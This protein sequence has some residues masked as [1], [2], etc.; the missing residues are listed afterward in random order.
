MK[1]RALLLLLASSGCHGGKK[2][3][4][5]SRSLLGVAKNA[6]K[7]SDAQ[8]LQSVAELNHLG[9]LAREALAR[10]PSR[11]PATVVSELLFGPLG[12][13]REVSD[14]A[15]DFVLLPSVL[16]RRRGSCV[17]L[18]TLFLALAER[19]GWSASGVMMPGHFYVRLA[20][21]SEHR[22]VEL[23][24]AGEAMPDTWYAERFP[25]PDGA[26]AE[27][28]RPLSSQEVLGVL[29][30]NVGNDHR[31]ARRIDEARAA[32][33]RSVS[34]FPD[35]SEAHAS[36]GAML[37]LL[38]QLDQ[39]AQSYRAARAKNP[40]LPGLDENLALLAAERAEAA[41]RR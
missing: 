8:L 31:R 6:A 29:E 24:R 32:F 5:F 7:L 13:V 17:G 21:R 28:A 40:H 39:A 36:L 3:L 30:Y 1:R 4:P 15:L 37:Q 27:Y 26:I 20:D 16:R 33:A 22:N 41:K 25:I 23:L 14:Q 38:G 35:F 19:L 34:A 11:P 10:S 18:G 9:D 12:F 2:G